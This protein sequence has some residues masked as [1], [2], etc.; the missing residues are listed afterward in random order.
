MKTIKAAS[1]QKLLS[2]CYSVS[3]DTLLNST[4]DLRV[5]VIYSL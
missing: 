4:I 5:K 3:N 2:M 1:L